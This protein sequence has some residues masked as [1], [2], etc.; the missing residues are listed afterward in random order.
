M[1]RVPGVADQGFTLL[2]ILIALT[3][4][5]T[6]MSV[7]FGVYAS[8]LDVARDLESSSRAD[9]M[10]RMVVSRITNDLRSY[11]PMVAA[12]LSAFRGGDVYLEDNATQETNRTSDKGTE[13]EVPLFWGNEMDTPPQ[14]E[15]G[16]VVMAFP[17]RASLGFADN[18]EVQRI[19]LVS[20]VL[21]PENE[22]DENGRYVL[23]RRELPF[24]GL[25]PEQKIEMIELADG[26]VWTDRAGPIY[27]DET[28][29][30]FTTWDGTARKRARK[31]VVPRLI[32]W[33]LRVDRDG[34]QVVYPMTVH[35][36]VLAAGG[37]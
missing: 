35:P 27:L 17:S 21:V 5:A 15:E 12:D 6:V 23:L 37:S 13:V 26:L 11:A 33:T 36:Q 8:C 30:R 20:Y 24:A 19:N 16:I 10:M 28:G 18:D 22:N 29:E 2:E 32:S 14:D 31:P 4:T 34:Q 3:M 7:L 9:R 1:D 25:Y